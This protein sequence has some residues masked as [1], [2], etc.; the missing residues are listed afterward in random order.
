MTCGHLLQEMTEQNGILS[1]EN[2][3]QGTPSIQ[4][5]IDVIDVKTDMKSDL[6]EYGGKTNLTIHW[7]TCPGGILKEVTAE[8]PPNISEILP[9][10]DCSDNVNEKP[11]TDTHNVKVHERIHTCVKPFTCDVCGK[12]FTGSRSLNRH[13]RTHTGV[14]LVTRVG[15]LVLVQVN[16]KSTKL[17][18]Q[19]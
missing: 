13:E 16:S 9:V 14:K 15:N 10:D 18:T 6:G 8:L 17:H 5:Y 2:T 3:S 19:V 12:S 1:F 4:D 7:V 11:I